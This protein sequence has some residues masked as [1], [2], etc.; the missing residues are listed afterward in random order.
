MGDATTR[1][2]TA[3]GGRSRK[4][5]QWA[6]RLILIYCLGALLYLTWRF[7]VQTLPAAGVSPLAAF[8]PGAHLLV[9]RGAS[10]GAVGDALLYRDEQGRLLLGRL[11]DRPVGEERPG[12]WLLSDGSGPDGVAFPDSRSLGPVAPERV[13]GRV[14]F[15]IPGFD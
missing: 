6:R 10:G 12:L 7:E 9:D 3:Q 4:L 11:A 5:L 15:A 8:R 13:E 2:G 1:P 14:V